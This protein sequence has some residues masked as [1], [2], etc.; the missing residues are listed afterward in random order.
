MAVL[1]FAIGIL[2]IVGLQAS[3]LQAQTDSKV[4]ADAANLVDEVAALMWSQVNKGKPAPATLASIV[5]FKDGTCAGDLTCNGWLT[6]LKTSPARRNA[7]PAVVRRD[8]RRLVRCEFWPGHHQAE[9]DAAQ[10][11]VAQ[12]HHDVQRLTLDDLSGPAHEHH[13]PPATHVTAARD[14]TAQRGMTLVELMVA[15]LLGLVT[16]L[17]HRASA[18]GRRPEAHRHVRQ[19]CAGQRGGCAA[20]R[21]VATC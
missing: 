9:L 19:R 11:G 17:L 16:T 4:R 15:L 20:H 18:R 10:R 21:C 1:L 6:K 5:Q 3:M 7:G 8:D 12:V 13:I 14:L 2:G